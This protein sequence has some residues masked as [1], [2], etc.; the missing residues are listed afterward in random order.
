MV[1]ESDAIQ[2]RRLSASGLGLACSIVPCRVPYLSF[3]TSCLSILIIKMQNTIEATAEI[4]GLSVWLS[5]DICLQQILPNRVVV[6]E[7][8]PYQGVPDKHH[9]EL[10]NI[11]SWVQLY[12]V[13]CMNI[14]PR[15]LQSGSHDLR[16]FW[17]DSCSQPRWTTSKPRSNLYHESMSFPRIETKNRY[18]DD[19]AI[20]LTRLRICPD[21]QCLSFESGRELKEPYDYQLS[22]RRWWRWYWWW[23][24]WGRNE[25]KRILKTDDEMRRRARNDKEKKEDLS[26]QQR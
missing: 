20:C 4:R 9:L 3:K 7:P 23:C 26:K 8:A 1:L 15:H 14:P 25:K 21:N 24:W 13:A 6:R 11:T 17:I 22:P 10:D 18:Y 19:D 2:P 12:G 16:V 5:K